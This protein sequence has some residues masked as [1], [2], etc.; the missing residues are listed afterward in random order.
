MI[1]LPLEK[2]SADRQA[3]EYTIKQIDED[4][5][6]VVQTTVNSLIQYA[7]N[8]EKSV[9]VEKSIMLFTGLLPHSLQF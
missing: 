6:P 5:I 7:K 9:N 2:Q 8:N 1:L 4:M 3:L